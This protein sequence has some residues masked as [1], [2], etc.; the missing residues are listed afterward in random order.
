MVFKHYTEFGIIIIILE[1]NQVIPRGPVYQ[2]ICQVT[3]IF[4]VN[5]TCGQSL[6][7]IE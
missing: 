6:C 2:L 7:R 3:G 4:K 5:F 1:R